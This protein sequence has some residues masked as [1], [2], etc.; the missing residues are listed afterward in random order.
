[1]FLAAVI[2]EAQFAVLYA[3][4]RVMGPPRVLR[5]RLETN[6]RLLRAFGARIGE[7]A[8][9]LSPITVNFDGG[10]YHNLT[11]GDHCVIN[12]NNFLDLSE[13]ITLEDYVSLGPGVI[14]MTHN[15]FNRNEFLE[16]RLSRMCGCKPVVIKA[17][18]GIKAN[19]LIL[20]GV[21]IGESAVVAGAS[22]VIKDV[23]A[24]HFV[25][26]VPAVTRSVLG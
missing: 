14:V 12:G 9:I 26:G 2:G 21:T 4:H 13:K 17:G 10:R 6:V 15:Q 11:V 8:W 24:R 20:H 7:G 23:P 1:L 3:W 19:A 5:F 18:A 16:R 22:V 25:S